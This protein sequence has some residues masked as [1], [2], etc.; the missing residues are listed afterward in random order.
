MRVKLLVD[1]V[2]NS[3]GGGRQRTGDI[4]VVSENEGRRMLEAGHAVEVTRV[5][6]VYE[7]MAKDQ[8]ARLVSVGEVE[9]VPCGAVEQIESRVVQ[10][11]RN[12]A[13]R[14]GRSLGV[15]G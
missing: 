6:R 12:A 11:L 7:W 4:V 13:A 14:V 2:G 8:A 10:P 15:A 1:R 5:K 9:L 3:G